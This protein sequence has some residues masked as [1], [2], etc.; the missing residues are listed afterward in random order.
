VDAHHTHCFL[1]RTFTPS[2]II[3]ERGG[4]NESECIHNKALSSINNPSCKLPQPPYNTV[5]Y[6]CCQQLD[7]DR[8]NLYCNEKDHIDVKFIPAYMKTG[9]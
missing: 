7:C 8:D 2:G 4:V 1:N 9:K 3:I 5:C 6:D